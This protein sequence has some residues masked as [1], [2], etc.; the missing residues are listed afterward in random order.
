MTT[1]VILTFSSILMV[2][3]MIVGTLI[4]WTANDFLYAY[5]NTRSNLPQHPEMYDEDGMV[6]NEELLSVRFVDEEDPEEDGYY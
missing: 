6:V 4:G 2:L 1:A 3:F 5:M